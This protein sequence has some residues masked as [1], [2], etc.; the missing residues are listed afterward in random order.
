M[1][2]RTAGQGGSAGRPL[3]LPANRS[4]TEIER[5]GSKPRSAWLL[6]TICANVLSVLGVEVWRRVVRSVHPDHDP[7]ERCQGEASGDCRTRSGRP[8]RS[9]DSQGARAEPP[10]RD[11]ACWSRIRGT[12]LRARPRTVASGRLE[13]VRGRN[14]VL[15]KSVSSDPR[16]WS[17]DRQHTRIGDE[18]S[19][20]IIGASTPAVW[21][22]SHRVRTD[23]GPEPGVGSGKG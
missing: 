20:T 5:W 22:T 16:C 3:T 1:L 17:Y 14:R 21:R 2:R 13:D 8:S 10:E 18:N 4:F 15:T 7:V 19:S 6:S 12:K 23:H 9:H 11:R